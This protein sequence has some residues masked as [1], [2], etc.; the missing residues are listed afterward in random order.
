MTK[1]DDLY[2]ARKYVMKEENAKRRGIPFKLTFQSY[3]NLMRAKKCYY[4]GIELSDVE[5]AADQRTIDRINANKGYEKGNV[6]A[7][8][9]AFNQLKAKMEHDGSIF[10]PNFQKAVGKMF[11][12]VNTRSKSHIN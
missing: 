4:T 7:C 6:V 2:L 12:T 8:C 5:G 11:K 1:Y 3:K 10:L 9:H